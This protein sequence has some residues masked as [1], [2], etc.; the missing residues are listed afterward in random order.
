[1]ALWLMTWKVGRSS[2]TPDLSRVLSTFAHEDRI[3]K[4][5]DHKAQNATVILMESEA[6]VFLKTNLTGKHCVYLDSCV[7]RFIVLGCYRSQ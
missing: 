4:D 1:M 6:P 2:S 5:V 3:P 7:Y